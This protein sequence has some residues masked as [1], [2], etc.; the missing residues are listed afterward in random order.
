MNLYEIWTL[1][2]KLFNQ[3]K[4]LFVISYV[5]IC[6]M[7]NL[8]N[9]LFPKSI[10]N[11]KNSSGNN[12]L[13][14]YV[15]DTDS[16]NEIIVGCIEDIDPLNNNYIKMSNGLNKVLYTDRYLT[17]KISQIKTAL[18]IKGKPVNITS[19][20]FQCLTNS[21]YKLMI[22]NFE[23]LINKFATKNYINNTLIDLTLPEKIIKLL[24]WNIKKAELKFATKPS[25]II[26]MEHC[27]YFAYLGTN[28]GCEIEK[29][30]P[31][32]VWKKHINNSNLNDNSYYVF[33][34]TS[35]KFNKS[36]KHNVPILVNGKQNHILLNQG[37][38]I[39]IKRLV[40][41]YIDDTTGKVIKLDT[42]TIEKIK[43][44]IKTYFSV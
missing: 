3:Y 31:V 35:K 7:K 6:T 30:R 43:N 10:Y 33:P 5:I 2:Q 28:I 21:I 34:I 8:K 9:K 16:A 17:L 14:V 40:K 24:T 39:S 42:Q 18:Y 41:P 27:V 4:L 32:I 26:I 11:Y 44:E 38:I 37:R 20:E 25:S 12:C 23:S 13:C 22:L 1:F 36:Y 29:L 19:D 15:C